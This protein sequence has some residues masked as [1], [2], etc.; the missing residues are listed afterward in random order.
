MSKKKKTSANKSA[1]KIKKI[2]PG[3]K[4]QKI[5]RLLIKIIMWS[6]PAIISFSA[7]YIHYKPHIIIDSVEKHGDNPFEYKFVVLNNGGTD[8]RE[9]NL[10]A[11]I[12][13]ISEKLILDNVGFE[14]Y[15]II[16]GIKISAG[17]KVYFN[18]EKC[19]NC[20]IINIEEVSVTIYISY[21]D[22]LGLPIYYDEFSFRLF[23]ET[24]GFSWRPVG[25]G[26]IKLHK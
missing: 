8:A 26:Y 11:T 9:F 2:T 20:K 13:I 3:I 10:S 24:N 19:I 16:D 18:L 15:F 25:P 17:Q 1:E 14:N 4:Y 12:N 21:K 22:S 5:F 7:L 23:K 6:I